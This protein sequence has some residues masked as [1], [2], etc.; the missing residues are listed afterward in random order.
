MKYYF[1]KKSIFNDVKQSELR[2]GKRIFSEDTSDQNGSKRFFVL[3]D[4]EYISSLSPSERHLYEVIPDV[5]NYPCFLFFDIDKPLDESRSEHASILEFNRFVEHFKSHLERYLHNKTSNS[6]T[7]EEGRT[8]QVKITP[9]QHKL[10]IHIKVNLL[11]KSMRLVKQV[12]KDFAEYLRVADDGSM[13]YYKDVA[14]KITSVIDC[15]V[16]SNFRSFRTLYSSKRTNGV[17]AEPLSGSSAS[18]I[19]H[20]VMWHPKTVQTCID[21]DVTS[22]LPQ[23]SSSKCEKYDIIPKSRHPSG[24]DQ[25]ILTHLERSS[26]L[27]HKFQVPTLAI[28][29]DAVQQSIDGASTRCYFI[30]KSCKVVCPYANRKHKSN[31]T[32]LVHDIHSDTIFIKCFDE[33]CIKCP[34]H[35]R[36]SFNLDTFSDGTI[37]IIHNADARKSL[38]T[39]QMRIQW[40]QVYNEPKMQPYPLRPLVCVRANM[41]AC[42]TEELV[43]FIQS[44]PLTESC[45][46]ITYQVMLAEAYASK[47]E[48][49][50]FCNY[51][52]ADN[53]GRYFLDQD[54]LVICLDS[55]WK[56]RQRSFDFIFVDEALSVLLHFNSSLMRRSTSVSAMFEYLLV[57]AKH[58]YF[59]DAC[60]D[61]GMVQDVVQ[62]LY[63]RKQLKIGDSVAIWNRHIRPTNRKCHMFVNQSCKKKLHVSMQE[64]ICERIRDAVIARGERVVVASTTKSFTNMLIGNLKDSLVKKG[65]K[66]ILHN[67][68]QERRKDPTSLWGKADLLIYSPSIGA[69]VSFSEFHFD[70]L[71]A[72][73]E[74]SYY[75]PT[76]D[77]VLQQLFRVRQLKKGDMFLYVND[78]FL[79]EDAKSK[80]PTNARDIEEWMDTN[81]MC[82]PD[83]YCAC[84]SYASEPT[85]NELQQRLVYDKSKLSY[86]I[87]KGIVAMRNMSL[88]SFTK[89]LAN[90]LC[91]DYKIKC[92]IDD[93]IHQQERGSTLPLPRQFE[94]ENDEIS[95]LIVLS[96]MEYHNLC[97]LE[98][99]KKTEMEKHMMW[100][101]E[102]T[103]CMWRIE[104]SRI[105]AWFYE[106]CIGRKGNCIKKARDLFAKALRWHIAASSCGEAP[107]HIL[108]MLEVELQSL[109]GDQNMAIFSKN[110]MVFYHLIMEG[111]YVLDNVFG[112]SVDVVCRL[113][114]GEVVKVEVGLIDF[115][116]KDYVSVLSNKRFTQL[117]S[118]MGMDKRAYPSL[119]KLRDNKINQRAFISKILDVSFGIRFRLC[120]RSAAKQVWLMENQWY[121]DICRK[122]K[123]SIFVLEN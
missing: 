9:H 77:F 24:G 55:L 40:N 106:H 33:E 71:F 56:V 19:D 48:S 108:K 117:R 30:D 112:A 116:L 72:Y 122:Y 47:L 64:Q 79:T 17:A 46:V 57:L 76:V 85:V 45:L 62:Y 15:R 67:G 21:L 1:S 90:T 69:G 20:L 18:L 113:M 28:Q 65:L 105:D 95:N 103:V 14:G 52:T 16:Y 97:R 111:K 59:V 2:A 25:D 110:P 22:I 27:C 74:N 49:I 7:L 115:K 123:P 32:F 68:D 86:R 118:L 53:S 96:N 37:H 23:Q 6:V 82:L 80:Y 100:I 84:L 83:Q 26:I 50:G 63:S 91:D 93:Y 38:H 92:T 104:P 70:V 42:K 119:E 88:Q 10:S 54:R 102:A 3:D 39:S 29:K 12:A 41:G 13:F 107:S 60:V 87:L 4:L 75:T 36:H 121:H 99:N 31:R 120:Q 98:A 66:W 5:D 44:R 109:E 81:T 43:K 51:L 11:C 8:L 61:N 114:Q 94:V 101:Y 35:L 34:Q 78:G 58:I 89:I 73:I